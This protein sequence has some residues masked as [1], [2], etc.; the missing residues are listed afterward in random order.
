MGKNE[1]SPMIAP[2]DCLREFPG[3]RTGMAYAYEEITR[4]QEKS[5]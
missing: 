3:H 1:V 5:T 4:D 2:G